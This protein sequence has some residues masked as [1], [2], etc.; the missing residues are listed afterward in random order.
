MLKSFGCLLGCC[1]RFIYFLCVVVSSGLCGTSNMEDTEP[2]KMRNSGGKPNDCVIPFQNEAG[3]KREGSTANC[4]FPLVL[5]LSG[6]LSLLTHMKAAVGFQTLLNP[7]LIVL[8]SLG[9]E[10]RLAS[11]LKMAFHFGR[12]ISVS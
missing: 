10:N 2:G 3:W 5:C 6:I 1:K 12:D 7:N 4:C 8:M 9:D 11:L